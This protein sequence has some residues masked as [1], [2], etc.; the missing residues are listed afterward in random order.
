MS[1]TELVLSCEDDSILQ[2]RL[3]TKLRTKF[4]I[5]KCGDIDSVLLL[6][7]Y[8]FAKGNIAVCTSILSYV[9]NLYEFD[10]K[11]DD[12]SWHIGLLV[13]LAAEVETVAPCQILPKKNSL[14]SVVDR[15]PDWDEPPSLEQMCREWIDNDH[16]EAMRVLDFDTRKYKCE[17]LAG[18]INQLCYFK[19]L[20]PLEREG[21]PQKLAVEIDEIIRLCIKLLRTNLTK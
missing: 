4:S 6:C 13:T 20:I 1:F 18:E 5:N 15:I 7:T 8:E 2:T 12:L 10:E 16:R 21:V 19:H 14:E 9:L 17:I 11:R 3:K